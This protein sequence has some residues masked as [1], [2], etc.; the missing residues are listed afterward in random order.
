MLS[1][2]SIFGKKIITEVKE[3]D[4]F[5]YAEDY[6]QDFEKKNPNNPYINNVSIPRFNRF[7]KKAS[8]YVKIKNVH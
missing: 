7:K 5:Y 4:K 2:N 1:T 6:H 3:I 8:N